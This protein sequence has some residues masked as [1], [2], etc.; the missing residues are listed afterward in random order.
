MNEQDT[1]PFSNTRVA[2]RERKSRAP[3]KNADETH[4]ERRRCNPSLARR[5]HSNSRRRRTAK[6]L[7]T[8]GHTVSKCHRRVLTI[9]KENVPFI[10]RKLLAPVEPNHHGAQILRAEAGGR[11]V[12]AGETPAASAGRSPGSEQRQPPEEFKTEGQFTKRRVWTFHKSQSHDHRRPRAPQARDA[13]RASARVTMGPGR[14][15][16]P[17]SGPPGDGAS[18]RAEAERV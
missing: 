8:E 1:R 9:T 16:E 7:G 10:W 17:G 18:A 5:G 13:G 4:A 12:A 11:L 15:P 3:R 14:E 2:A 6:P